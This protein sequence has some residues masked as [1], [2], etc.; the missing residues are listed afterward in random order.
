MTK[1]PQLEGDAFPADDTP[2]L[3]TDGVSSAGSSARWLWWVGGCGCAV[4][5]LA[6]SL[7]ALFVLLLFINSD[8]EGI[9]ESINRTK[10]LHKLRLITIA[11]YEY[12][13]AHQSF[14]AAYNIDAEGRPLLSWRVHLLPYLDHAEL[15]EQFH[16]DEPWD[17]PHNRS[18]IPLM[19]DVYRSPFSQAPDGKT[20]YLG[21]AVV[22]G[23]M[24]KPTTADALPTGGYQLDSFTKGTSETILL[25]EVNDDRAVTWTRPADFDP[26]LGTDRYSWL[27]L[28]DERLFQAVFAD[29]ASHSMT[30]DDND[31]FRRLLTRDEREVVDIDDLP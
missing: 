11:N 24:A 2:P 5:A 19:P 18:L 14:P 30:A 13:S 16:L 20:T 1:H 25:L 31:H 10:S 8:P 9:R 23:A 15:Y 12:W 4:V 7:F 22:G 3:S 6:A 21:N 28:N 27:R 29:G 26:A 17:S